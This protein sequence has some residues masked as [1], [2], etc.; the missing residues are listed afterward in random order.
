MMASSGYDPAVGMIS[1]RSFWLGAWRLTARI[2]WSLAA[3]RRANVL[4]T[5]TV[6]MVMC[7]APM[8]SSLFMNVCA[9][10]TF[11]RFII[12]SPIPMLRFVV[13]ARLSSPGA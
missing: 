6:E 7:R 13:S 10:R 5:P 12:G 4:G 1:S 8:P 9:S 2:D 11:F 3:A